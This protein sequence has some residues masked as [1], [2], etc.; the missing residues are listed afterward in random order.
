MDC[1]HDHKHGDMKCPEGVPK[2][3]HG[4]GGPHHD[5]KEFLKTLDKDSQEVIFLRTAHKLLHSS[6]EDLQSGAAFS[7]LSDEEKQQ[8]K[9]ILAKVSANIEVE[10]HE[11][12]AAPAGEA[13]EEPAE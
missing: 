4:H 11:R 3:P 6:K 12:P 1:K 9:D 7:T 13:P 2:G 5:R 10:K 8:L